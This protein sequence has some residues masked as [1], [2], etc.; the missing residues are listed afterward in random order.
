MEERRVAVASGVHSLFVEVEEEL[1][2]GQHDGQLFGLGP[3]HEFG[4]RLDPRLNSILLYH[5]ADYEG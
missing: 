5:F 3:F 1:D 4:K 2:S